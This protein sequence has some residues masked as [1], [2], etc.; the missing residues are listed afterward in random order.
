LTQVREQLKTELEAK[1]AEL[2]E[3][4]GRS[5]VLLN[6]TCDAILYLDEELNITYINAGTEKMFSYSAEQLIGKPLS[7]L[8]KVDCSGKAFLQD[9]LERARQMGNHH[10]Y[11]GK[12]NMYGF[13]F[14]VSVAL[15]GGKV[16]DK[17]V[18]TVIIRDIRKQKEQEDRMQKTVNSAKK[19]HDQL[20]RREQDFKNMEKE[21]AGIKKLLEEKDQTIAE[22]QAGKA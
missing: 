3:Q 2:S 5:E 13:T 1:L 17:K 4:Q 9:Y 21:L 11:V 14:P 15:T 7:I 10:E 8:F 12:S 20:M 19:V 22:L 18:Y 16:G 6:T